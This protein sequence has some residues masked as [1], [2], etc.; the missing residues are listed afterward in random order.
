MATSQY[1]TVEIMEIGKRAWKTASRAAK[2]MSKH[3]KIVNPSMEK[4]IPRFE[5]EEVV[6][7][8]V[9]GSGGFNDVYEVKRISL[10][11]DLSQ[12][13]HAKKI[14]SP[15]QTE[16]RAFVAKHVFRE[17]SQNC[18]YAVKFLSVETIEDPNRFCTGAADLVVVRTPKKIRLVDCIYVVTKYCNLFRSDYTRLEIQEAKF[19][20]SLSHPNIIKLRGMAAAGTSGFA[21]MKERGYFLLLDRLQCTLEHKI[22]H[23]RNFESTIDLDGKKGQFLAERL[24][25][26]FD[27]AAALSYLHAH[28]ILY[29]DLK[30]D[31][32]GFD[33]R[34]TSTSIFC[35]T[36]TLL[37]NQSQHHYAIYY[38]NVR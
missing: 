13:K 14:S 36:L 1:S 35:T 31:N 18:R 16:H 28:N 32:I 22:D 33:V 11:E 10:V 37:T 9:L 20:A 7:G 15:L 21:S 30:P 23:W 38:L 3:S 6:L 26:A 8:D 17:S 25:V 29:R 27:V 24:H 4:C 19:L 12:A 5:R 34:G 2:H